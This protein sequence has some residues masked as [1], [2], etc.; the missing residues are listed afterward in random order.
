MAIIDEREWCKMTARV[1]LPKCVT[2]RLCSSGENLHG[3][4]VGL[5]VT[6]TVGSVGLSEVH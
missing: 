1:N 5:S 2:E 6:G 3:L 4:L